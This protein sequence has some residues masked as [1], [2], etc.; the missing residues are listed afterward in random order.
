M[1]SVGL[2]IELGL[3]FYCA[4]YL[5]HRS[6]ALALY[7][8]LLF[9]TIKYRDY[10]FLY[11]ALCT[12]PCLN[13]LVCSTLHTT[14]RSALRMHS[15]FVCCMINAELSAA[16]SSRCVAL[17]LED[18]LLHLGATAVYHY[19]STRPEVT[20]PFHL[21]CHHQVSC[22]Q[23]LLQKVLVFTNIS[24]L[25]WVVRIHSTLLPRCCA[26]PPRERSTSF[27]DK[28]GKSPAVYEHAAI[29]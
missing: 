18:M 14:H 15:D 29:F 23:C 7:F 4:G 1:K 16:P 21:V 13:I 24:F 19:H 26:G 3:I 22:E 25:V 11:T 5:Y 10:K 20:F 9:C 17:Q 28:L 8:E 2:G 12:Y 6:K 27:H